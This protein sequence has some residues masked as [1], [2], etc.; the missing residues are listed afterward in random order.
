MQVINRSSGNQDLQTVDSSG[1]RLES[2]IHGLVVRPATAQVDERG[3]LTEIWRQDWVP[4]DAERNTPQCYLFTLRPGIR[5]GWV[6]HK[7]QSDR[8]FLVS[9]TVRIALLDARRSSPTFRMRQ[10]IF[11]SVEARKLVI[12]PPYVLHAVENVGQGDAMMIN[13]PTHLYNYAEP[14]KYRWED[15]IDSPPDVAFDV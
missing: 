5:K 7:I 13:A 2:Q 1:R 9:G 3:M 6:M 11:L 8:Q 12:I 4:A 15:P 10:D 14:D